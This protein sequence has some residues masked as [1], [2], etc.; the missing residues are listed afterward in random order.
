MPY[1]VL[2]GRGGSCDS[3]SSLWVL[4]PFRRPHLGGQ[5]HQHQRLRCMT[6]WLRFL[7]WNAWIQVETATHRM[8]SSLWGR[9]FPSFFLALFFFF[10]ISFL[11]CTAHWQIYSLRWSMVDLYSGKSDERS[12]SV[13]RMIQ[14]LSK[15]QKNVHFTV[16]QSSF[17]NLGG[18]KSLG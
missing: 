2:P 10:E 14:E 15:D 6:A 5:W 13:A 8:T 17:C 18:E 1:R 12:R 9:A 7:G 16:D 4:G 11:L 3:P